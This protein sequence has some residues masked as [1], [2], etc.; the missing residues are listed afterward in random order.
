MDIVRKL[1][2]GFKPAFARRNVI[3]NMQH[4]NAPSNPSNSRFHRPKMFFCYVK[5][6][7]VYIF[8]AIFPNPDELGCISFLHSSSST[9]P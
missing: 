3:G 2:A 9:V 4:Q 7:S 1:Y 8:S 5:R 6:P